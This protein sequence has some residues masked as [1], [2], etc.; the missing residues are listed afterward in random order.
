MSLIIMYCDRLQML[1]LPSSSEP[2]LPVDWIRLTPRKK[3]IDLRQNVV[4][5]IGSMSHIDDSHSWIG[6]RPLL[7]CGAV[8]RI[9][10]QSQVLVGVQTEGHHEVTTDLEPPCLD[11]ALVR[12]RN[13]EYDGSTGAKQNI[14]N[15][16]TGCVAKA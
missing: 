14:P 9:A 16:F 8:Q 4:A 3:P 1:L 11:K 6:S 5:A 7:R 10:V 13:D 15:I 2:Y 12:Y